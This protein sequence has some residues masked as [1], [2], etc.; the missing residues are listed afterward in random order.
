NGWGQFNLSPYMTFKDPN[1]DHPEGDIW[2]D[3]LIISTQPIPMLSGDS[4]TSTTGPPTV[5]VLKP[6]AGTTVSSASV[7][8]SASAWSSV[9]IAGVQFELDGANLGPKT[10]TAPYSITW[11]TTY[12]SN[13]SHTL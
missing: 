4:S 9:G 12:G 3:D 2:F 7:T 6:S 11:D 13:G 10:T 1:Q 8:V 5:S